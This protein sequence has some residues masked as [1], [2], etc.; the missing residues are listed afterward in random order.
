MKI[1]L[2][3]LVLSSCTS[4]AKTEPTVELK[5]VL[6]CVDDQVDVYGDICGEMDTD[7]EDAHFNGVQC[8]VEAIKG[9]L[10]LAK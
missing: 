3:M 4:F 8:A 10:E 7:G 9:C 1:I 6:A 2:I 5:T